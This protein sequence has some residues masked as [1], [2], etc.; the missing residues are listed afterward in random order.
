MCASSAGRPVAAQYSRRLSRPERCGCSPVPSTNE[1]SRDS[2]GAPGPAGVPEDADPPL[3]RPDQPHEHP[4]GR[5]LAGAVGPEQTEH[6]PATHLEGEVADGDEA[7]LVR[8]GHAL[9][10]QRHVLA[11][12]LDRRHLAAT[13]SSPQQGHGPAEQPEDG[14]DGQEDPPARGAGAGVGCRRDLGHGE[15]G[16]GRGQADRVDG[17]LGGQREGLVG[18]GDHHPHRVTGLEAVHDARQRHL[19]RRGRARIGG[20]PGQRERGHQTRRQRQPAVGS[21]VVELREQGRRA[22]GRGDR[23]PDRRRPDDLHRGVQ[24]PAREEGE[25]AGDLDRRPA[26][27][28]T[29]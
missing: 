6:L 19:D 22:A 29:Q 12:R 21:G 23:E 7:V 10:A 28:R 9:E 15:R 3:G 1:P 4:Q 18:G 11:V 5:R 8:L 2:T 16:V 25:L 20:E 26:E 17:R 24:R 13:T 27:R 14:E